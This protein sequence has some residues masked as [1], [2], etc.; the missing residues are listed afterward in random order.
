MEEHILKFPKQLQWEAK[1][2]NADRLPQ[3]SKFIVCGMGGSHLAAGILKVY[4]PALD[5]LIHRDYGLPRVPDYFLRESLIIASSHSGNTEETLDA[6]FAAH[7]AG[8]RVAV[9]ATGGKLLD[10]A[11]ENALPYVL[12]PGE[13]IQPRLALGYQLKALA[14]LIN[15]QGLAGELADLASE[16]DPAGWQ[17]RGREIAGALSS[18]IPV[19]Y[20]SAV[21]LPLAYI[22]KIKFNENCKTPAFYSVFPE[23][24]HNELTGFDRSGK[25]GEFAALMIRDASDH[26][27]I[28]KRFE[29]TKKLYQERGVGVLDVD[30]VGSGLGKMLSAILLADWVTLAVAQANGREPEPVPLI[31]EFK[32]LMFE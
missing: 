4:N 31:E 7:Q 11:R 29:V 17:E 8:L 13:G 12:Y 24:N 9:I 19:V 25:E 14:A 10:F 16:L 28:Q 26:A 5:L 32:K 1:V 22:W 2:E 20:A 21:N 27:R 6:A 15:N 30:L 18:K 23:L 3:T